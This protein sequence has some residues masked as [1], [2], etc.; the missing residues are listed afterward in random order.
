MEEI[1]SYNKIYA[2][3]NENGIVTHF[4]SEAFETPAEKDVCVDSTNIERHGAQK[5]S[6]VDEN[7]FYNYEIKD[8]VLSERDKT[9]DAATEKKNE[10]RSHRL[11]QCFPIINRGKFWYDKLTEEQNTELS[12]W[13]QAWLDAPETGSE[14]EKPSWLI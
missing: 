2:R 13:Y 11:T 5:Y 3:T 10:I 8:G 6:V 14:P 12:A 1:I 4:F 7:G 9:E